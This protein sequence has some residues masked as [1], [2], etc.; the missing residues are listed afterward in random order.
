ML[1]FL[2]HNHQHG[3]H[4]YE[5]FID[6]I[7]FTPRDFNKSINEQ[8]LLKNITWLFR[9][10][11]VVIGFK[12]TS[13]VHKIQ[14]KTHCICYTAFYAFQNPYFTLNIIN[15]TAKFI[16][17]KHG[18]K[19]YSTLLPIF[20]IQPLLSTHVVSCLSQLN[21]SNEYIHNLLQNKCHFDKTFNLFI[22]TSYSF[23]NR[24]T[25][26]FKLKIG[27]FE[28]KQKT[29]NSVILFV[30][31]EL[32]EFSF[33]VVKLMPCAKFSSLQRAV[34]ID[35]IQHVPEGDR[36]N[37]QKKNQIDKILNQENCI[38]DHE[39]TKRILLESNQKMFKPLAYGK[40]QHKYLMEH[41]GMY[42]FLSN[43]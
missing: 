17:F 15:A 7:K 26:L 40:K 12:K 30:T 34:F 23:V 5:Q 29:N 32:Q 27:H 16:L 14:C 25:S 8:N 4:R 38:C 22:Y 31:P 1:H 3:F 35:S 36:I 11:L 18:G 19:S 24:Y 20:N 21:L 10:N 42:V 33:W 28:A 41:L 6:H 13:N 39:H 37:H 43:T 9:I 2:W